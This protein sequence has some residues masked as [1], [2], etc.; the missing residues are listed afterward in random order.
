MLLV[1]LLEY[2]Q[3]EFASSAQ[4][5]RMLCGAC[6]SCMRALPLPSLGSAD[7]TELSSTLDRIVRHVARRCP[8]AFITSHDTQPLVDL[9]RFIDTYP[10]TDVAIDAEQPTA[11]AELHRRQ[12]RLLSLS[13]TAFDVAAPIVPP[14][15][16]N[17]AYS[18]ARSA[19]M[20]VLTAFPHNLVD[21][22]ASL[23]AL[24]GS[25]GAASL[26]A[27][28]HQMAAFKALFKYH[29]SML[30][31]AAVCTLVCD[32]A[33]D[34]SAPAGGFHLAAVLLESVLDKDDDRR[35][36]QAALQRA[37]FTRQ[38]LI[39]CNNGCLFTLT[40]QIRLKARCEDW[41]FCSDS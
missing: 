9:Q 41:R 22:E 24:H 23:K 13:G 32:W 14:V 39:D 34:G 40:V 19:V 37:I 27:F 30:P 2:L 1:P 20:Q 15:D 31:S 4:L 28:P 16:G 36:V 12:A 18:T 33:V 3:G 8:D 11:L 26:A 21:A 38:R 6:L 29:A 5:S 25:K 7:N 10:S 17:S 35:A